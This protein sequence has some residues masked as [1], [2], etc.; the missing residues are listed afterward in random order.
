MSWEDTAVIIV[1]VLQNSMDLVTGEVGSTSDPCVTST[2]HAIQLT[3]MEAEGVCNIKQEVVE[4]PTE[5]PLIKMELNVSSV[6]VVSVTHISH[7]LYPKLLACVSVC[8]YEKEFD[9]R[10][11][12]FEEFLR[13][14]IFCYPLHF[15]CHMQLDVSYVNKSNIPFIFMGLKCDLLH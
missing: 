2:V 7:G 13:K 10:R 11:M 14:Q 1:V 9:S 8:P 12:D 5:I 6:P 15:M 3:G 4:E